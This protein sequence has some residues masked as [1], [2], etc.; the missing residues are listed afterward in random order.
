MVKATLRTSYFFSVNTSGI[1]LIA[2]RLCLDINGCSILYKRW[3]VAWKIFPTLQLT[4]GHCFPAKQAKSRWRAENRLKTWATRPPLPKSELLPLETE[5]QI[6]RRPGCWLFAD[7]SKRGNID[8]INHQQTWQ[9]G[10]TVHPVNKS[11]VSR[12]SSFMTN[13][14]PF[15]SKVFNLV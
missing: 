9:W 14:H 5:P 6:F 1:V 8:T 2:G 4:S 7:G 3:A 15:T 13:A 12:V 11:P 10:F